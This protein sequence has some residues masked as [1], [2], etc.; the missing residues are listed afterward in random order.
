MLVRLALLAVILISTPAMAQ[1]RVITLQEGVDGYSGTTDAFIARDFPNNSGGGDDALF[2]GT[3][4]GESTT[5]PPSRRALLR[6]DLSRLP[7]G[8]VVTSATLDLSV[9]MVAPGSPATME[10][11]MH[12]L[13]TAWGEGVAVGA[14]GGGFGADANEGD[15]TWTSAFHNQQAWATEGGDFV[16]QASAT[17]TV[18]GDGSIA[19]WS[20]AGLV[21]DLQQWIDAP[22]TNFGWIFIGE[23]EGVDTRRVRV[24]GSAENEGDEP[25]LT[26]TGGVPQSYLLEQGVDD[27]TGFEDTSIFE[28]F[29]NN[30]GGGTDGIFTGTIRTP[31]KNSRALI[32]TDLSDFPDDSIVLDAALTLTVNVSGGFFG[33]IDYGLHLMTNDWG[34]GDTDGATNPGSS[35]GGAGA[36]AADGDATW[37]ANFF[38]QSTWTTPGGDFEA[39]ASAVAT[40]G[41]AGTTATWTSTMMA[42]DVQQWIADPATNRGWILVSTIEGTSQRVKEFH[43]SEASDARPQLALTV[44]PGTPPTDID[45]N[46]SVN[47]VDIQLVINAVLGS[48]AQGINPDVNNDGQINSV[49]IQ[50]VIL[51]VLG[52]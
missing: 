41:I 10:T 45:G 23:G 33:D 48:P 29:V 18:Q 44:I 13:S 22:E 49:D 34:E 43:S 39:K 5:E 50:L 6:F 38:N 1:V 19:Q 51:A 12:R 52:L 35:A 7:A 25:I 21:A 3:T 42:Q 30:S 32:R 14:R 28:A 17:T 37:N 47:S 16:A 46:G 20:G 4:A 26:I 40:V 36:P 2:V 27:Y 15:A 11:T 8:F 9:I 31:I 24:F